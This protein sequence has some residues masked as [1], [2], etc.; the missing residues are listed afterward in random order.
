MK[1]NTTQIE[2]VLA[3]LKHGPITPLQMLREHGIMRLAPC[4]FLLRQDGYAIA[5]H[6]MQVPTRRRGVMATVAEYTLTKRR[7]GPNRVAVR[8]TSSTRRRA[9]KRVRTQRSA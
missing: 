3:A 7:R 5:T 2:A 1:P 4:I 8:V 6:L 9:P